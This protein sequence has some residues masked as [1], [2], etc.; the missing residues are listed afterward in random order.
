[1][2]NIVYVCTSIR[3]VVILN[4]DTFIKINAAKPVGSGTQTPQRAHCGF[5]LVPTNQLRA[6]PISIDKYGAI[7]LLSILRVC[8]CVRVC[9]CVR[10]CMCARASCVHEH[11]VVFGGCREKFLDR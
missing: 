2:H 10:V 4:P 5:A 3:N 1:M 7:K 8:M 9:I 6:F 11:P